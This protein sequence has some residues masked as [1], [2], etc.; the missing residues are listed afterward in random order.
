M[1]SLN[2]HKANSF[3]FIIIKNKLKTNL[4]QNQNRY[5]YSFITTKAADDPIKNLNPV[6]T[7][8]II[9]NRNFKNNLQTK[10]LKI[11]KEISNEQK[12][13]REK[14][15]YLSNPN[16]PRYPKQK[17]IFIL[18]FLFRLI[19]FIINKLM[20]LTRFLAHIGTISLL[21]Y[22]FYQFNFFNKLLNK[23][24]PEAFSE[25]KKLLKQLYIGNTV[26]FTNDLLCDILEDPKFTAEMQSLIQQ[27]YYHDLLKTNVKNLFWE[28]FAIFLKNIH[29]GSLFNT[30][31]VSC[32]DD[33][34]FETVSRKVFLN[35]VKSTDFQNQ[36]ERILSEITCDETFRA[37]LNY[38]LKRNMMH[39]VQKKDFHD[40]VSDFTKGFL[41]KEYVFDRI[42][43]YYYINFIS[44]DQ[45]RFIH[46]KNKEFK[47]FDGL[48]PAY[49]DQ[50]Y[51]K[52]AR[53]DLSDKDLIEKF[54]NGNMNLLDV[55]KDK[56]FDFDQ[57]L[58]NNRNRKEDFFSNN[59]LFSTQNEILEF[60]I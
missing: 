34:L 55:F 39:Y 47:M 33:R 53:I 30:W 46:K 26:Q 48:R 32:L 41:S 60:D 9:S 35:F 54:L 15:L 51:M 38:F 8:T 5:F 52:C 17:K 45:N 6:L 56:K 59:N 28:A 27:I 23:F 20:R 50:M 43:A 42:F 7:K 1:K 19:K 4:Y 13:K 29:T 44:Q 58:I 36:L 22:L 11:H 49:D 10:L 37:I 3:L 31:L 2:V 57:M 24:V 16:Q 14:E 21:I 40:S 25:F 12:A 18:T